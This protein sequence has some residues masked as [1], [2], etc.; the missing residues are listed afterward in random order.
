VLDDD[1]LKIKGIQ[2]ISNLVERKRHAEPNRLYIEFK[3][4]P[5]EKPEWIDFYQQVNELTSSKT[6]G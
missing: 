5:R 6:P 4:F 1:I 3:V 2:T